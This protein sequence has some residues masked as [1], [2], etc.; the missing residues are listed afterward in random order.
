[1]S[2]CLETRPIM[3]FNSAQPFAIRRVTVKPPRPQIST[4]VV[5]LSLKSGRSLGIVT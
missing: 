4:E 3:L 5:V 2:G 1:M